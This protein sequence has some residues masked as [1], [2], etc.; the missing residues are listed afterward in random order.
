V[1]EKPCSLC[2]EVKSADSFYAKGSRL[3]SRC[4]KCQTKKSVE[5]HKERL[6][7]DPE[8]RKHVNERSKKRLR[9]LSDSGLCK[10]CGER[11]H[12]EDSV[13]C[14]DCLIRNREWYKASVDSR[15][16][17]AAKN[18]LK[19]KLQVFEAYGGA[20]CACCGEKELIF[21]T[22]DHINGGGNAERKKIGRSCKMFRH[23]INNKFPIGYQ[24]LCYNCNSGK[25]LNGGVCPHQQKKDEQC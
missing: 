2:K 15:R 5:R 22:L 24:V 4:K 6:K 18:R 21:L 25:H 7:T 16:A 23:L 9:R 17:N 10:Y 19:W 1:K 20:I 12:V 11:P 13:H 8:Y 14:A 3:Q